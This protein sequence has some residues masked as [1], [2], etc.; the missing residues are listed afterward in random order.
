M[1]NLRKRTILE[2]IAVVGVL[3]ILSIFVFMRSSNQ[4]WTAMNTRVA[5][6]RAEA[7]SR[8]MPWTVLHG[9][10]LPGNAWDD[11]QI[12]LNDALTW[13][14]DPNGAM[15]GRFVN[16][17]AT[18]DRTLID[19]M[20]ATHAEAIEHL[21]RGAQK[22]DG[23]YPYKWEDG[24]QAA[25]PS[26]L[27]SRKLVNFGVAQA[28]I[29]REGG[30]TAEAADLLLDVSMFARDLGA[31]GVLLTSLI[32]DAAYLITFNELRSLVLSGK[33]TKAQL[34]DLEKKLET[35]D[36]DFP[37]IRPTLTNENLSAMDAALEPSSIGEWFELTAQ[38]GWRY[39]LSTRAMTLAAFEERESYIQRTKNLEKTDFGAVKKEAD[40][41]E[42]VASSSVNPLIRMYTPSITRSIAAHGEALARLRLL[43][44]ATGFLAT[45]KVPTVPDPF[46]R[47]LLYE[48]T[49]AKLRIWSVGADG[50]DQKGPGVWS[51]QPRQLDIVIEIPK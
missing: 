16:G 45:G 37:S 43:R 5:E 12:A 18:V 19:Q 21:R 1:L 47:N 10:P 13:S 49:G 32:G 42:A 29:W 35:L 14:E 30:R 22:T 11:Y 28:R 48:D 31:N 27:A 15:L 44:A 4:R 2:I 9:T 38:G 40:A 51:I 26:I 20:I 24:T 50:I 46:G 7:R 25:L 34:A 3:G 6:L 17:D 8:K 36:H 23:Q 39:G 41:L 33:L